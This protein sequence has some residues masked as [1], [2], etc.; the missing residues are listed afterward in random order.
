[1]R[2]EKYNNDGGCLPGIVVLIGFV[3]I[4][5]FMPESETEEMSYGANIALTISIVAVGYALRAAFK[6]DQYSM[7]GAIE[8]M[9]QDGRSPVLYLRAFDADQDKLTT[10]QQIYRFQN[11]QTFMMAWAMPVLNFEQRLTI[12]LNRVGP[13]VALSQPGAEDPTGVAK[14]PEFPNEKWKDAVLDLV[15]RSR[16]IVLRAAYAGSVLWELEKLQTNRNMDGVIFW[17][18][19]AGAQDKMLIQA[20]YRH[21]AKTI[22]GICGKP[23]PKTAK[24][25]SFIA[26]DDKGEFKVQ[27]LS[28]AIRVATGTKGDRFRTFMQAMM[29]FAAPTLQQRSTP[30]GK[31]KAALFCLVAALISAIGIYVSMSAIQVP[32][33]FDIVVPLIIGASFASLRRHWGAYGRIYDVITFLT[34]ISPYLYQMVIVSGIF[35]TGYVLESSDDFLF[36]V[37]IYSLWAWFVSFIYSVPKKEKIFASLPDYRLRTN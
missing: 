10:Q 20:R 27:S 35:E 28:K 13:V 26:L 37:A 7:P 3:C 16:I 36:Y 34:I 19:F 1:M 6:G 4:I 30:P 22:E 15:D 21:F 32:L 12:Q 5:Y 11:P 14:L 25:G 8:M 9:E 18:Q 2:P 24:P 17:V 31:S 33:P 29:P 23:L